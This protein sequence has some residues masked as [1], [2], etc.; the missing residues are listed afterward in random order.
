MK[1][2]NCGVWFGLAFWIGRVAFALHVHL[3][4][5]T[6][7]AFYI[8]GQ[9]ALCFLRASYGF[10]DER[11]HVLNLRLSHPISFLSYGEPNV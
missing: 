3:L 5:H 11:H 4:R 10:F 9:N 2:D 1:I 8:S 7:V 6:H